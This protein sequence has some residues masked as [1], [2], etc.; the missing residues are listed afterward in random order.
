MNGPYDEKFTR[1]VYNPEMNE[2]FTFHYDFNFS[3][4]IDNFFSKW[5]NLDSK[6]VDKMVRQ[7]IQ[8]QKTTLSVAFY[9]VSGEHTF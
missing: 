8:L 6:I 3:F 9:S 5:P 7:P 2:I 4:V 1:G